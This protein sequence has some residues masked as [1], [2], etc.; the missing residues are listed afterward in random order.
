MPI[1]EFHCAECG[2]AFE[3]LVR[4]ITADRDC[5]CPSC[6]GNAV[7]VMSAFTAKTTHKT[8]TPKP[9]NRNRPG[10]RVELPPETPRPPVALGPPPPLPERY[11]HQ[12]KHHGHC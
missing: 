5:H 2:S 12:L 10:R 7:R 1:Y 8:S 3:V 9:L 4:A 11:V 6:D